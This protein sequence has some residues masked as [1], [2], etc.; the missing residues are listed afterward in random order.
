MKKTIA[1]LMVA[2]LWIGGCSSRSDEDINDIDISGLDI[3]AATDDKDVELEDPANILI[4]SSTPTLLTG[5]DNT[6]ATI[7]AIVTD[8]QNRAVEGHVVNFGSDAGVL[9]NIQAETD[10]SGEARAELSLAGDLINK[11]ITVTATVEDV[12]SQTTVVA[13]GTTITLA[14]P[15]DLT[16][17]DVANL[18][19]T[20][21][22]GAG[23]PIPNQL[24][25]LSS[26]AGTAFDRNSAVTDAQGVVAITATTSA[27]AD[28]ITAS[29][30]NGAVL[31]E[32]DL[33]TGAPSVVAVT[34]PVRIRVISNESVI[35]TGGSDVALITTL[36][37]DEN[38]RVLS[39]REVFF[40]STGGVLQNISSTTNDA[41]QATAEL[42]L[43]GDFR[44]Q[45]IVVSA[46]VDD[47]FGEVL[48]TTEGSRINIAGPTALV[49]GD[50][51]QFE[52]TLLAGNEQPIANE[53]LSIQ[54]TA[55]NTVQPST[56]VTNADGRATFTVGS[57]MGTDS[58]IVSAL[59]STVST[60]HELQVAS[61]IL[62]VV[63]GPHDNLTVD[64]FSPFS[65][66]WTSNGLPVPGR[67][68]RFSTTAGV[69]RGAGQTGSNVVVQT[70]ASGVA[71]VELSSN[72]AGPATVSFADASDSD[73]ASQFEV[74]FVATTPEII[75]LD[76]TPASVATG[77]TSTITANVVDAFGNPV[78]DTIVEF[79]SENL[80]GGSLSPVSALTNSDGNA[81]IT[82]NAGLLPTQTDGITVV[83]V[84]TEHQGT[85]A[86]ATVD[87]TVTER[88]LNVII[89][90]SGQLRD[91]DSDTRYSTTGV[92][93]VTDG[94]GRPVSDA[95]I[96]MSLIPTVY[97]YGELILRDLDF[98]GTPD[99]WDLFTTYVCIAEDR[100]GNRILDAGED[101]NNNG[102]LDQG[103]DTDGD[104][105][106]DL[107][108]DT[109]NNG[110]LDPPDPAL[111]DVDPENLPTVIGSQI[112]T[113]ASGVGFFSIVYPQSNAL[114]F[115]VDVTA[116]VEALGVE[117]V[118][119]FSTILRMT[120]ADAANV[121]GG[122][123]NQVSPYGSL[124]Q[125]PD[126][127]CVPV[128]TFS[129][130][131]TLP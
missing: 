58:I 118:A 45:N 56:V 40:S 115:D 125:V 91:I 110:V 28:V 49:N 75:T 76:A 55:G 93:Q 120:A 22:S 83:A 124:L 131:Q 82:F 24:I 61:D 117:G 62:S 72:S 90:I 92:V 107:P 126:S 34:T 127:G 10:E 123:P 89:G 44:N 119:E 47:Q 88:Q 8:E 11:T 116:R 53:T 97:R 38:N 27:T 121:D 86:P 51:A 101:T 95:T 46:V 105:M 73:P 16:V 17:G 87:L 26:E 36:V 64:E 41:G 6:A 98:D 122:P 31:V 63:S 29:A 68:M 35:E 5:D 71:R 69:V 114:Y 15:S 14:A 3:G 85:V 21:V 19:F 42:S 9:R 39:D 7:S 109:N 108:E 37:T 104:G 43:T 54:S 33:L 18:E 65:V 77:N 96:Q 78:R 100:N 59:G 99:S 94:A 67:M 60:E 23:T 12:S 74:E 48:V 103:E 30:L 130:G 111:I 32:L 106:L 129:D 4:F 70:N 52:V 66:L 79:S 81:S 20:L 13:Q 84:A 2:A 50:V 113:D 25:E 112:T 128:F 1:L 80:R 57:Q 102:V